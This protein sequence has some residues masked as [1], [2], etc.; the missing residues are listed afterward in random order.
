[1]SDKEIE[2]SISL[3][4]MMQ[5]SESDAAAASENRDALHES[6]MKVVAKQASDELSLPRIAAVKKVQKRGTRLTALSR[7]LTLEEL[8][9]H[10]G[11][12]IAEVAREF[13]ICTTFL[14]K[15]CRRCGIKRWPHRQIRSLSRTILMLEQVK[16]AAAN[17]QERAKYATQIE[18]LKDQQ[19]AVM[20]DPDANGKLTRMKTYTAPKA[21]TVETTDSMSIPM[22]SDG[23]LRSATNNLTATDCNTANL[24]ALV[25]AVDSVSGAPD[26]ATLKKS[27]PGPSLLGVQI[28]SSALALPSPSLTTPLH[29]AAS[30]QTPLALR[31]SPSNRT[32]ALIKSNPDTERRLRSSSIASLQAT[33]GA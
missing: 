32:L 26:N 27:A 5:S 31:I 14:K 30:S 23:S 16:S 25:V 18:E 2:A 24:S 20:E 10:F 21:V 19:R 9:P 1:M 33:E 11:R 17:P 28:P 15:I 13:G 29:A 22:D 8:R 6:L 4:H 3:L 7:E 12:P